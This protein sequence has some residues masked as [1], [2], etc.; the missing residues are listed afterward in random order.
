MQFDRKIFFDSVRPA[1]FGGKLSQQQVDGMNSI[2]LEW[3]RDHP[4]WD[5]R[6]LAYALAT[7]KHETAS[8]MW[9]IEEY[10]KGSGQ[11][12]GEPDPVTGEAYY[13]RG[14]VQLTWADNYKKA[15]KE[16]GLQQELSCYWHPV[17]ALNTAI[18]ADIMFLGMHEGWFR[19]GQTFAKYFS[20]KANDAY[21]AR[22]II[23]G[24][25]TYKPKWAN[26][27]TIGNIIAGYHKSFLGALE[28][29]KTEVEP[30]AVATKPTAPADDPSS[31]LPDLP[32]Q[33]Y[34]RLVEMLHSV[35]RMLGLKITER[36]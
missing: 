29:S 6:W 8:T 34:D 7:T 14:F 17:N 19:K 13:G 21:G 22:E 35:A 10:G 11:P 12:Y 27:Q 5:L 18:A 4:T 16:L 20:D 31:R 26:G 30:Q 15:D 32:A 3:E 36:T 25:K 24:D 2:L 33:D 28:A 9:P 1:L 23:N